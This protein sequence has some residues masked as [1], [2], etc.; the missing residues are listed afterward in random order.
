MAA[1]RVLITGAGGFTGPYVCSA[2]EQ[3]GYGVF[4]ATGAIDLLD[5]DAIGGLL[6][7]QSFDYVVHLAALSTI[8]HERAEDYYRVN[9]LGTL[10]LL[11]A[12]ARRGKP[13]KIIL[14]SSANVYGRPARV[15]VE[16]S[17]TPAPL[18][19]YAVSKL[20]MEMMARLWF[21]RLPILIVR[22]FN[23][24]GVGQSANFVLPKIIGAFRSGSAE[25]ELGDI[26]VAREFM[27][28]RDVAQAYVRLLE[29]DA[30]GE[31]VN[32]CAG[33][34]VRLAEVLERL[35][36]LTGRA[37]AL[38]RG[39]ALV[40]GNEV[41]AL[42]GSP[43]KLLRLVAGLTFRPLDDTLRWMLG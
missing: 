38:R 20:A 17:A 21:G 30:A 29:C 1:G 9:L 10:N 24:S 23:Y 39:A 7:K 43:E 4:G 34:A 36:A 3:R 14:A 19:H 8:A 40:R 5:P 13:K 32:L 28:V 6:A 27:D 2:L 18:N 12:L 15:P 37:P 35:T 22:P 42:V 41:P 33:R 11:E 31:V 16:E 25:V 26:A